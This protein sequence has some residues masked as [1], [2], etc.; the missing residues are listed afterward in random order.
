VIEQELTRCDKVLKKSNDEEIKDIMESRIEMIN[1]KK[2]S[3]M[4][5]IKGGFLTGPEYLRTIK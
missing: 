4:E 2:E 5:D 3:I 1:M